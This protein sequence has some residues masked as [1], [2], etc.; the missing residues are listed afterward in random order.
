MFLFFGLIMMIASL[1]TPRIAWFSKKKSRGRGV[2]TWLTVV[3]LALVVGL[4]AGAG[5]PSG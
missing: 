2:L 3:I 1:F 5:G 4:A